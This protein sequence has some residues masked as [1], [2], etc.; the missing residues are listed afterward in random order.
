CRTITDCGRQRNTFRCTT[1]AEGSCET[2]NSVARARELGAVIV[3]DECYAE[4][5]WSS[6]E[7]EVKS[8]DTGEHIREAVQ[9]D[10]GNSYIVR[11]VI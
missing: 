6:V 3:G 11:L 4:L 2:P 8:R 10:L 5:G 1:S 7:A 9:K